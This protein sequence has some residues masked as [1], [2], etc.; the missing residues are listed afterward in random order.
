MP[1]LLVDARRD[2]VRVIVA[3]RLPREPHNATLHLFSASPELVG[4]GQN[5]YRRRSETTSLLVGQLFESLRG[6]GLRMSYTIEDFKRD[7]AKKYWATPPAERRELLQSLPAEERRHV[8][9]SLPAGERRELLESLPVEERLAGLS[10]EQ[11]Q[12]YLDK[13]KGNRPTRRKPGR[14]K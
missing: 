7:L 5:A 10:R 13:S 6:E 3:G 1:F 11:I 14:K 9:A 8:V 12:Q 4:F 2:D